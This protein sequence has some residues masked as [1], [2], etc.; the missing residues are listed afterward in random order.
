[1]TSPTINYNF[2]TEQD[3]GFYILN[4]VCHDWIHDFNNYERMG[5]ILNYIMALV[6]SSR[7]LGE[8]SEQL[9]ELTIDEPIQETDLSL[10]IDT[11]QPIIQENDRNLSDQEI[12]LTEPTTLVTPISQAETNE[13]EP[14]VKEL[15][16]SQV[17]QFLESSPSIS[18]IP[19]I[20]DNSIQGVGL[21]RP[22]EDYS[23]KNTLINIV[24]KSINV[25]NSIK[26]S[27]Q[28][29]QMTRGNVRKINIL[30]RLNDFIGECQL[31]VISKLGSLG[32]GVKKMLSGTEIYRGGGSKGID[33]IL[34]DDI[35]NAI[36]G[37]VQEI[38]ETTNLSE[39]DKKNLKN[40]FELMNQVFINFNIPGI[41]PLEKFNNSLITDIISMFIVNKCETM[42]IK[43]E[44]ILYLNVFIPTQQV[45]SLIQES[46]T[47]VAPVARGISPAGKKFSPT[48]ITSNKGIE[49]PPSPT[50]ITEFYGGGAFSQKIYTD[51]KDKWPTLE[52]K[53]SEINDSDLY[54]IYIGNRKIAEMNSSQVLELFTIYQT[55]IS[56]MDETIKLIIGQQMFN[57]KTK[58][59]QIIFKD[60]NSSVQRSNVRGITRYSQEMVDTINDFIFDKI[61]NTYQDIK[62]KSEAR[63][64]PSSSEGR[65]SG[66]AQQAVQ[67]IS[68]L[69][70]KKTLE[71]TGYLVGNEL[72]ETLFKGNNDLTA[73]ARIIMQTV[74]SGKGYTSVDNSLIKYFN[75]TYGMQPQF[76]SG[77]KAN[78]FLIGELNAC[79]KS[80]CRVINNAIPNGPVKDSISNTVICP[81]SSVCDGM[82]AFGSCVTPSTSKQEFYNMDFY[83]SYQTD[84][85]KFYTG[86]TIL[87]S[88]NSAVNVNYGFQ[89][90]DLQIYNFL[91][92]NINTQPIILQ[93]NYTFKGVIAQIITIWKSADSVTNIE[94]LWDM[95]DNTEYFLSILK[96]GSQKAVGDIFQE[97]N[98]TLENGGYI[99][100][101]NNAT[102]A[103]MGKDGT[104]KT[105]GLM[106]D[107]PSGVRIL[108]LL[109][110]AVSGKNPNAY[111]GYIGGETSL[112][113][114]PI[115]K[116]GG[117]NIK[118]YKRVNRIKKTRRYNKYKSIKKRKRYNKRTKKQRV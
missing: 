53:I 103:V 68:K 98:S 62:N 32:S 115:S 60:L 47:I 58:Q 111:G 81:T 18:I 75:D 106:G 39:N 9:S 116:I 102:L 56:G 99:R 88:N 54:Q 109:K 117:N 97:I 101:N 2:E 45:Q 96:L 64:E 35:S 22:R 55:F 11:S 61:I 37:I 76:M 87:K 52:I 31:L 82:G 77:I 78:D 51:N 8:V 16:Q 24:N 46:Q 79:S 5:K 7:Q 69:V 40:I 89:F 44:A 26:S 14:T 110:D 113:Y 83:V 114:V 28:T 12:I 34:T 57:V 29:K 72:N 74:T 21:K 73:Q 93:A 38:N 4:A 66:E 6:P 49:R 17:E 71:L 15:Y 20:V 85:N 107:R 25:F 100:N 3:L 104:K 70:A 42:D 48:I 112:I 30:Q 91:D 10:T 43:Q 41:S 27:T 36:Y 59:I 84:D 118:T 80:L 94:Q 86:S 23:F 92:I 95:L 1:M 50:S 108:K 90:N 65:I 33:I 67:Q 63:A 105:F 19:E 13:N